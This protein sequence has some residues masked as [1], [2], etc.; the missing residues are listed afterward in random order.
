MALSCMSCLAKHA[1]LEVV[2]QR[3]ETRCTDRGHVD[4]HIQWSV[5]PLCHV[6]RPRCDCSPV[7]L[8]H[9]LGDLV[10]LPAAPKAKA[11]SKFNRRAYRVRADRVRHCVLVSFAWSL[12]PFSVCWRIRASPPAADQQR[13]RMPRHRLLQ[14][15]TL[16]TCGRRSSCGQ[17][18]PSSVCLT[19]A[20]RL[21]R[22]KAQPPRLRQ[23]EAVTVHQM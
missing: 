18:T 8:A 17:G 11:I 7:S 6:R 22:W 13:A 2:M 12:D 23:D 15:R 20:A 21:F 19:A 5:L 9:C 4:V 3:W 16:A 14:L 10:E 1:L